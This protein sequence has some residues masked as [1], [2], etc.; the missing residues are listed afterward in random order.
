MIQPAFD[1]TTFSRKQAEVLTWWI[2][3]SQY[4]GI[5]GDGAIRSGKTM[6]FS[7]SFVVWAM[8]NF[9]GKILTMSGKTIASFR[10][11]VLVWL[12]QMLN[13]SGYRVEERKGENKIIVRKGKTENTFYMFG[14]QDESSQ[15][16]IQGITS[17][18]ALFDEVA[19]MPESFVNQATGRCSVEGSK[20]WFNCNPGSPAHYFRSEWIDKRDTKNL[21]YIHFTMDDNPS[22]SEEKKAEYRARYSGVF[23]RRFILGEWATAD[24]AIYSM[25]DDDLHVVDIA[26]KITRTWIGVDYG[27]SNPTVFL[28][29]GEGVDG[30]LYVLREYYHKGGGVDGATSNKSPQAYSKDMRKFLADSTPYY[31]ATREGIFIDPSAAGFYDQLRA[32]GVSNLRK[33][34]N[35]VL[36]GIELVSR[37]IECDKFRVLSHCRN[38]RDELMSYSWDAKASRYGEDRPIKERDH[39][40][41]SLRYSVMGAKRHWERRVQGW[42]S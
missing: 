40:V 9:N 19:L 6:A 33:A 28:L 35:A 12:I 5:I 7:L 27:H 39:V 30:R 26:P 24:G 18:G 34:D 13:N 14:G 16:L 11:N 42:A 3:R 17:A 25:Y 20:L 31:N 37:L 36:P 15:Y 1:F 4:S 23:Y 38:M 8:E 32:D 41:D 10:R 21:Y 29:I 2:G 22:L